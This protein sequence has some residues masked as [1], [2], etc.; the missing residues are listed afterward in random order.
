LEGG[1]V[2]P[3]TPVHALARPRAHVSRKLQ[4]AIQ[5]LKDNPAAM[6]LSGRELETAYTV[7]KISYKTWN[8]AKKGLK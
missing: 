6:E 7:E 8:K 5:Y 3:R 1:A 4:T 2:P